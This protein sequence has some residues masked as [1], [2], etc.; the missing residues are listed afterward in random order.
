MKIRP[1]LSGACSLKVV[2]DENF[3][4]EVLFK[5]TEVGS[6]RRRSADPSAPRGRHEIWWK[7][8]K[9]HQ[10]HLCLKHDTRIFMQMSNSRTKVVWWFFKD[11]LD[12]I[13]LQHIRLSGLNVHK[14]KKL[15][16]WNCWRFYH[17]WMLMPAPS[18]EFQTILFWHQ[19]RKNKAH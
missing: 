4:F 12:I 14:K 16:F 15:F 18:V 10:I 9:A 19:M 13:R 5:L 8:F 1:S 11:M 7:C 6:A 3:P 2:E 17:C